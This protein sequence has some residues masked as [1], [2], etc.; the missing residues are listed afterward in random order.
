MKQKLNC[1]LLI[2]DDE[3]TNF[4]NTMLVEELDC[5]E[6]IQVAQSG[7]EALNFLTNPERADDDKGFPCPDLIFL[8]IN[9]PAMNG[10]EFLAKYNELG[11]V[12]K[13]KVIT[14]MLTTSLNPDDKQ[15]AK[16]NPAISTFETKPLTS[17]KLEKILR[18]YF[19]SYFLRPTG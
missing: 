10:W 5:A 16:E 1:I 13:G 18:E 9:M 2:D 7:K 17:E 15:R 11:Q 8:D 14:V 4:I 6:Y 19:P 3:P 12:Y